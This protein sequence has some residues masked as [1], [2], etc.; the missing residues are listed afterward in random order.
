MH[1]KFNNLRF[2]PFRVAIVLD[3]TTFLLKNLDDDNVVGG[4][5]NGGYLKNFYVY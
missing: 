5:V 3:N 4:L 2:G 1:G